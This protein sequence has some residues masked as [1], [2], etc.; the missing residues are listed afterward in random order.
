M[1]VTDTV[2][3]AAAP[4][5]GEAP[6]VAGSAPAPAGEAQSGAGGGAP[7]PARTG[8]FKGALARF[9]LEETTGEA[10]ALFRVGLGALLV[11]YLVVPVGLNLERYYGEAGMLPHDVFVEWVGRWTLLAPSG[12]PV[13]LWGVWGVTLAAAVALLVGYRARIAAAAA[14]V[15]VVSLVNRNPYVGNSGE[16]LLCALLFLSILAPL[17]L[18]WSVDARRR[19]PR[20]EPVLGLQIIRIELVLVYVLSA[21]Q[22]V[23]ERPWRTGDALRLAL[24]AEVVSNVRGGLGSPAIEHALTYGALALE[25]LFFLV[26]WRRLRPWVLACGLLLHLSIEAVF[27]IPLFSATMLVTYLAFFTDAEARRVVGWLSRPFAARR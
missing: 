24:D 21:V 4:P 8:G 9:F 26:F 14:Y 23:Q 5:A 3:E 12:S 6:S 13:L 2:E 15:G 7:A 16:G 11:Y 1:R 10:G 20:A 27:T 17:S 19:G 18:R 22:K 25:S